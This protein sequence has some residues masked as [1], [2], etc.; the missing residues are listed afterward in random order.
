MATEAPPSPATAPDAA[1][2]AR[3]AALKQQFIAERG[4]WNSFW[5]DLL[6]ADPDYFSG[7]LNFSA[8]PGR[9]GVLDPKV[10]EFLYIAIDASATHMYKPGLR[11]HVQNA[12][13]LG[14]TLGE[15]LDVLELTAEIGIHS[16]TAGLPILL[17]EAR[18][19]GVAV[20]PVTALPPAQQALR[21]RFETTIGY[22]NEAWD[23]L[24][25]VAPGFCAAYLDLADVPRSSPRLDAK[26]RELVLVALSAATTN[27]FAA[28]MRIH[29]RNALR[30]GA[31]FAEIA[32]VLQLISV[33]GVHALTIGMPVIFE[34][35][36]KAS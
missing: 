19:A 18:A 22:W 11:I 7:Y 8:A 13:R 25:R 33:L 29:I 3:R 10:R 30:A 21:E 27:L 32:E 15:M 26:T 28:G 16:C 1:T 5:D 34:E 23:A 17:E 4:Y 12:V 14:A 6:A 20:P 2:L 9:T 36:G 35:V 31:T 24:L